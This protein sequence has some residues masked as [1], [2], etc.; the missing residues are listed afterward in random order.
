[1]FVLTLHCCCRG[2]WTYFS[3]AVTFPPPPPFCR[4]ALVLTLLL[5]PVF[6]VIPPFCSHLVIREQWGGIFFF[7]HD[8]LCCVHWLLCVVVRA[9]FLPIVRKLKKVLYLLFCEK[10]KN[11]DKCPTRP[12]S[13]LLL[14]LYFRVCECF[15]FVSPFTSTEY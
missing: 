3:P 8:F 1:M 14:Y 10:N 7:P 2:V 9:F 15:P 11:R 13:L 12:S 4:A 6:V 5:L